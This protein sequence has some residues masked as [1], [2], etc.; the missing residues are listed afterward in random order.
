MSY[1]S[2]S[3]SDGR[4]V[5]RSVLRSSCCR[6][7]RGTPPPVRCRAP[8]PAGSP[9][10]PCRTLDGV[11]LGRS[12]RTWG[13]GAPLVRAGWLPDRAPR[14]AGRRRPSRRSPATTRSSRPAH[15]IRCRSGTVRGPPWRHGKPMRE[16]LWSTLPRHGGIPR[17]D[18]SAARPGRRQRACLSIPG[19]RE[20]RTCRR[21]RSIGSAARTEPVP[22]TP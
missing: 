5:L 4:S 14:P 17:T 11:P 10:G 13:A 21:S 8:F 3:S 22:Q 2:S 12:T 16:P 15:D 18:R 1:C 19:R 6:A 20:R 7:R 9:G